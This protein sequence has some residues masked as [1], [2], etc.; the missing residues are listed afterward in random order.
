MWQWLK[1]L[2]VGVPYCRLHIWQKNEYHVLV[3][4]VC[5]WV[6]GQDSNGGKHAIQF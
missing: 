6:E 2:F 5:G 1:R 4:S 3:C